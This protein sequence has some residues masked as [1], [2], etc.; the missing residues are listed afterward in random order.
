[1]VAG[2]IA[3]WISFGFDDAPGEPPCG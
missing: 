3:G 2:G 1:M